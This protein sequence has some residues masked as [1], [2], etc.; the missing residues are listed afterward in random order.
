MPGFPEFLHHAATEHMLYGPDAQGAGAGGFFAGAQMLRL[1]DLVVE[2][3]EH[4]VH[5]VRHHG[6]RP[7]ALQKLHQM[8]VARGGELHQDLPHDAHPGLLDVQDGDRI[9]LPDDVPAHPAESQQVHMLRGDE[10]LCFFY[11][12]PVQGIY[13]ARDCL[14][15][16]HPVY[17]AHEDVAELGGQS[18]AD[19]QVGVQ[20]E[21]GIA[22]DACQV[23]GNH[24][25]LLHARLLQG[26]ADEAHVVGGPAA[27]SGLAHDDGS[28]LQVVSS[29][30]QG[31]H[32]L[33]HHQ[34]GGVTGVIV[35]IFQPHIHGMAVVVVQDYEIVAASIEGRLHDLEVDGGHLGAD[36]GVVPAH[37]LGE[38]HLL[39]GGGVER[40]LLM[41]LL[42]HLDGGEQGAHP[43]PGGP[44][45]VHLVDL[46]AGVYLAGAGQDVVHLIRGHRVQAAAEGVQLDQVQV[47]HRP[48][49][50][51]CGIEPGVVHPLIRDDQ[52]PL[53]AAQVGDGV[54]RQHRQVE[55]GDHLRQAVVDLR[56]D[57]V[58]ASGQDDT[59]L[60]GLLKPGDGLLP[61]LPHVHAGAVQLL[62]A[63]G[64]GG[65][66]LP[67]GQ[68]REL[69]GQGLRD[70]GDVPEG[71]EGIAQRCL[72]VSD[73]L[74]IVLDVLGVGGDDGAVVMVGGPLHLVPLIEQGG[75]EDEVHLLPDQ[76]LHMPV[77]QLG[78]VALRFAG[79]GLDAQLVDLAVGAGGE[80]YPVSQL[81]EKGMPEGIVLIHVQHPGDANRAPGSLVRGQG[82]IGEQAL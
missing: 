79:D 2:A 80:D 18:R 55:G 7:F 76:P 29:R 43:D 42:P 15:G 81:R 66:H 33:P 47:V 10:I 64:R 72:S 9:E 5:Q 6:L 26:P 14:I 21:A 1:V 82:L 4:E 77:G 78:G 27:P 32:D 19:Q 25:N 50:A 53:R 12:F 37:L 8:V 3:V 23:Q 71:Q 41:A 39:Y 52:G 44:Q 48:H 58:R 40:A 22:L 63:G 38:G 54:L 24:G 75:V 46:Q 56:V 11:P 30:L 35:H 34:Q 69:P 51:G 17:A 16:A 67:G 68:L 70:G 49:E 31:L 73:G 61:L 74:H 57:V 36:D 13:T 62:P 60:S 28:L 45:I 59:A 65:S 20:V